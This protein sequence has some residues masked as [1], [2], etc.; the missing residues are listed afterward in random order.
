MI[1]KKNITILS[2][3]LLVLSLLFSCKKDQG[4][5]SPM[6]YLDEINDSVASLPYELLSTYDFFIGELKD[7]IP[8]ENLYYYEPITP[9]FTDYAEKSRYIWIPKN[10]K[11]QFITGNKN[12]EFPIGTILIKNFFYQNVLPSGQTKI[13]ETRLMIKKSNEWI[14]AEYVWN[15]EQTEAFLDMNGSYTQVNWNHNGIAK[16]INYRIPSKTECF[17]CHK[18]NNTAIPLG[19]K[20]QNL[21]NDYNYPSGLSNQLQKMIDMGYLNAN[22]DMNFVTL[23]NYKDP[24]ESLNLR[25]RSYLDINCAHCH[26]ENSHCDYRSLRL[27]FG[28]TEYPENLGICKIPE[29]QINP[30]KTNIIVPGNFLKSM[31]H[32]RVS[33]TVTSE[34]MPL[35]GTRLVH[36]EFVELLEEYILSLQGCD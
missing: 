30:L 34:R 15:D 33:T 29:E 18:Q 8:N 9:L 19:V 1:L 23:V 4:L 20:P 21:N 14:F 36:D 12:L 5:I 2:S 13:I 16:S 22:F 24:S 32:Y 26:S 7:L 11:A 27:A 25:L 6:C 35:L 17:T 3:I 31:M 28:E 10:K